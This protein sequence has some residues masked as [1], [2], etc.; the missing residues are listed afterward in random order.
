MET[1]KF[2]DCIVTRHRLKKES[3][4][5]RN[6]IHWEQQRIPETT[7]RVIGIRS[8]R[9]GVYH[10]NEDEYYF[11]PSEYIKAALVVKNLKEKPFY[12]KL[13]E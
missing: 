4:P 3:G 8:L 2:G 9:N 5:R 11:E 12:I 7:V 1:Y 10:I 6:Q 13:D